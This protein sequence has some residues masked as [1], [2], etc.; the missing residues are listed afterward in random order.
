[1][2]KFFYLVHIQYL[3]FRFHGWQKQ[4]RL[5]T[6]Q[7]MVEKTLTFVFEHDNFKVMTCSRTDSKVSANHTAFELFL[8]ESMDMDWFMEKFN[9]N[10]PND[11]RGIR[12]EEVDGNFN[13]I[14]T[15]KLKN[16]IYLFTYGEK[17]HPFA[18]HLMMYFKGDLDIDLMQ[19]GA[20]LFEG[21]HN[22]VK[23]CTKPTPNTNFNREILK[24][25][26]LENTI[27]TANFFPEQSFVL[28]LHSKG[29]MRYQARLIMGQLVELGR[30]HID[31][32]TITASLTGDDTTAL[33]QIAPASGLILED[34]QFDQ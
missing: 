3:G 32:A 2:Q 6:V 25:E 5:K 18:A 23:Y 15:P 7:M 9:S 16:Y 27:Y 12:I 33:D 20:K 8:D 13:I 29:F 11:I 17:P 24:C 28:H 10:L 4:P 21:K 31:L 26:L 30:H 1:M 14:Q 34:V 19:Q 22:F